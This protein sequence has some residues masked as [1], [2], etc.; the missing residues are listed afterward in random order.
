MGRS[1]ELQQPD[2]Y[3]HE[4]H[5]LPILV[6]FHLQIMTIGNH[7]VS[8]ALFTAQISDEAL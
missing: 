5:I 8:T 2:Q 7:G 3:Q 1:K 6:G 4:R